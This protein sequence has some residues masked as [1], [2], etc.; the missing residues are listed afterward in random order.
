[1]EK[2]QGLVSQ[3]ALTVMAGRLKVDPVRLKETLKA[4]VCKGIKKQDGTYR[5]ITDDE[6]VAFAVVANTYK[7]NPFTKEIYAYPD[8]KGGGVIPIVSTDGWNRLMTTH[9]DYK[10]HNYVYSEEMVTPKGGKPCP[11]WMEIHIEKKDDSKVVVREYLDECY[12]ELKYASPWQT[13]TKR[14]LRHKTKIQGAREAFGFGGIYDQDEAERI[15][16]AETIPAA[17]KPE[18]EQPQTLSAPAQ[19]QQPKTDEINGYKLK[20]QKC[21]TA[22]ERIGDKKYYQIL[23]SLGFEHANQIRDYKTFDNLLEMCKEVT[24]K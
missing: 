8:T 5:P 9:P 10:T 20:L 12:R 2:K 16:E 3:N 1:M 24:K 23:G 4:T 22:K 14:M 18:V 21:K 13:H 11:E 15:I 6:F 7:L 19:E 17:G